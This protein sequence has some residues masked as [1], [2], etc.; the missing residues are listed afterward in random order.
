MGEGRVTKDGLLALLWAWFLGLFGKLPV[1]PKEQK[2]TR[3][4]FKRRGFNTWLFDL[5]TGERWC[6]RAECVPEAKDFC[7]ALV[8]AARLAP[9]MP[10]REVADVAAQLVEKMRAAGAN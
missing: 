6:M 4:G 5:E 3:V 8:Q 10:A 7:T 1:A 2:F 9:N